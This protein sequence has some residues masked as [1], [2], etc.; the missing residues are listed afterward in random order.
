MAPTPRP[1]CPQD[2]L[3]TYPFTK[4]ASWSSGSTYFHMV[5]GSL[6]RGSRLLCETSLVS[7]RPGG[8]LPA[9]TQRTQRLRTLGFPDPDPTPLAT[10]RV[11]PWEDMAPM[12]GVGRPG[13]AGRG[14][15]CSSGRAGRVTQGGNKARQGGLWSQGGKGTWGP[16]AGALFLSSRPARCVTEAEVGPRKRWPKPRLAVPL[17][18]PPHPSPRPGLQDGRP[19]DLVRAAAAEHR[20]QAAGPPD[21]SPGQS[22]AAGPSCPFSHPPQSGVLEALPEGPSLGP[23]PALWWRALKSPSPQNPQQHHPVA[24]QG[25]P[26]LGAGS[27][28]RRAGPG[29]AGL[30]ADGWKTGRTRPPGMFNKSSAEQWGECQRETRVGLGLGWAGGPAKGSFQGK[31]T[32]PRPVQAQRRTAPFSGSD[33]LRVCLL[34]FLP[35]PS[36]SLPASQTAEM[37]STGPS[38]HL[39]SFPR[40]ARDMDTGCRWLRCPEGGAGCRASEPGLGAHGPSPPCRS[41]SPDSTHRASLQGL[42]VSVGS[43]ALGRLSGLA[44]VSLTLWQRV[45]RHVTNHT[46]PG[47]V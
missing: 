16:G 27:E 31:Q 22:L 12:P 11:A 38:A 19:A 18:L 44:S 25:P 3:T 35:P 10:G 15:R 43:L 39:S 30:Q 6:G 5:L 32:A 21:L 37:L 2:L 26:P 40:R 1:L 45:Q 4:I 42:R 8:L 23:R 29:Q 9:H 20:E 33:F 17:R 47:V 34:P 28:G 24:P 46:S 41:L 36:P 14:S 7:P 13:W